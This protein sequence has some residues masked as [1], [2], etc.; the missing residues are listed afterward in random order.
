MWYF[1]P[2][3]NRE[4]ALLNRLAEGMFG[5]FWGHQEH[6][7]QLTEGSVDPQLSATL[8]PRMSARFNEAGDG[9]HFIADMPGVEKDG[10]EIEATSSQ[11]ILRGKGEKRSY[12]ATVPLRYKVDPDSAQASL[13]A[14]LLELDLKL[15]TPLKEKTTKIE[16]R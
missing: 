2:D 16:V 15:Q 9:L 13:I 14:G 12:E 3:L 4:F 1:P 7:K 5:N 11:L 6:H 10:L 8:T